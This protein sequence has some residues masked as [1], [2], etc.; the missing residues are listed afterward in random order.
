MGMAPCKLIRWDSHISIFALIL[1][2]H[3]S[4]LFQMLYFVNSEFVDL[5]FFVGGLGDLLLTLDY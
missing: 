2:K 4:I 3:V 5:V 1:Q